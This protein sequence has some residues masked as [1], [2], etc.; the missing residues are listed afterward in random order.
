MVNNLNNNLF[1][2]GSNKL[3]ALLCSRQAQLEQN[4]FNTLSIFF[5]EK[6]LFS[7]SIISS[8][9][10]G[11]AKDA[12]SLAQMQEQTLQLEQQAKLKVCWN[13]SLLE[14]L[15]Q[16]PGLGEAKIK[17]FPL[18]RMISFSFLFSFSKL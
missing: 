16:L 12:L 17:M 8:H 1:P 6:R 7:L 15:K 3:L 9:F 13:S 2:G 10:P 5:A 4:G 11:H 18:Q 14:L